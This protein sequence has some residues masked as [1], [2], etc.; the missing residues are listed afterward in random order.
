M[1]LNRK[2]QKDLRNHQN[3][4]HKKNTVNWRNLLFKRNSKMDNNNSKLFYYIILFFE[5]YRSAAAFNFICS[6]LVFTRAKGV[7]FS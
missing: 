4:M 6:S 5:E 3:S 1:F 2:Q 7:C